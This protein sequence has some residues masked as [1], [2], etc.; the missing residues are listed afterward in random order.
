[1]KRGLILLLMFWVVQGLMGQRP[2]PAR[3]EN[4]TSYEFKPDIVFDN[5]NERDGLSHNNVSSLLQD[6]FGF[7]WIG[8]SNGLNRYDG[9][10][11]NVFKKNRRDPKSILSNLIIGLEMDENGKIY[12]LTPDGIFTYDYA[13]NTFENTFFDMSR[14]KLY[15]MDFVVI[16]AGQVAVGTSSS[17][18]MMV[19]LK[20]KKTTLYEFEISNTSGIHTDRISKIIKDPKKKGLWLTSYNGLAY[21]DLETKKFKSYRN[22][23][24]SEIFENQSIEAICLSPE[25]NIWFHNND[26]KMLK[27]FDPQSNK[28]L[29]RL[30]LSNMM[31]IPYAGTL[32][33]TQ[34]HELWYASISYEII[35]IQYREGISYQSIKNDPSDPTSIPGNFI[36]CY[37]EDSDHTLWQGTVAGISRVNT[38]RN[39]YRVIPIFQKYPELEENNWQI[40]CIAQDPIDQTWWWASREGVIYQYNPL[41]GQSNATDLKEKTDYRNKSFFITDLEFIDQKIMI[42]ISNG[43]PVAW[44]RRT[45]E[46]DIIYQDKDGLS[47]FMPSSYVKE[48]DSTWI[49]SNN[50]LPLLRWNKNRNT[51]Q[52]INYPEA[53]ANRYGLKS[54][55]WMQGKVNKGIWVASE[56]ALGY[57][58]PGAGYLKRYALEETLADGSKSAITTGYYNSLEV[59]Q[60][61]NAWF[62]LIGNGLYKMEKKTGK[63]L[64][65][66]SANGLVSEVLNSTT[67]SSDGKI[68]CASFNKYS[69]FDPQS[70]RFFNFNLELSNNNSFYYN[71][72]IPL[73]NGHVLSTIKGYLV[74]FFPEKINRLYPGN[75]PMISAIEVPSGQKLIWNQNEL[76]LDPTDNFLTI[77]FASLSS[78]NQY[79]YFFK[80]RIQGIN[81]DW[82]KADRDDKANYTNLSPGHYIFEL[83][84]LSKDGKWQSP[85]KT[86]SFFIKA[87]FYKTWWFLTIIGLV[88]SSVIYLVI[89]NRIENIQN[90]TKLK[91]MA[92]LLEKEKTVVMYEN[93]K[94]H[95]NPHFLF[96]SL[97][98]LGSLIRI[99]PKEAGEFLDTM[100]KVYRYILK[101][102]ENETVVLGEELKFVA[103]YI[104]L[105][106]TRFGD[107]L[108]INID[109]PDEYLH[110]RIAP[111]TLQNLV[112]N[113]IKHNIADADEPLVVELYIE[114]DYLVVMNHLRRKNFVE[115]SNQQGLNSMVSLYRFLSDRPLMIEETADRWIVK[116]PLI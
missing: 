82:I 71:Y 19:D 40:T 26:T 86:L 51:Y 67:P 28:I 22:Q 34:N 62:S 98:S 43:Y 38:D 15:P 94:Q 54:G 75:P 83:Q 76:I 99:N 92:Q 116:V 61:G 73:I 96:N 7:L 81:Q 45:N 32:F 8:T 14:K 88:L 70:Q 89:K 33:E 49:I 63:C 46:F 23:T 56:Q 79:D 111:V 103:L 65:W 35:R 41:N 16:N 100:S 5:Y 27:C 13:E 101:N 50:S 104:Q 39:F 78:P 12:G 1:M 10:K 58:A 97:T 52:K 53:E 80:Y 64:A 93:L 21:F 2:F 29:Y 110:R 6:K 95:L 68:W 114:D 115:T 105:Q 109:I 112:E 77:H 44:D 20:T 59:D 85:V 87:P 25:G 107:G 42:S 90:I 108:K 113:A 9:K 102:K 18:L 4:K 66:D 57:L 74:E 72:T 84:A 30:D 91:S 47:D 17:G 31:K 69:V 106:K 36:S 3:S 11:F 24:S 37:W 60:D 48:T 55:N